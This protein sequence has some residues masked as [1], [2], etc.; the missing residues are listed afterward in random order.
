MLDRAVNGTAQFALI[1]G[2]A[3]VGKSSLLD[4]FAGR[5]G[6][7][8]LV[9]SCL[10][11]GEHGVPFA[12]IVE[13]LRSMES[14]PRHAAF[15][16]AGLGSLE[17]TEPAIATGAPEPTSR[18][19]LFQSVLALLARLARSGST[20][21]VI[22]DIHWA[23]R[24][25]RD[26]LSFL[27]P[28][29]R[30][31]PLLVVMT[32]RTEDVHR[33]HPL[34][35]TLAEFQR[36]PSVEHFDILSFDR[37]L[38]A[39]HI[40]NL[41]G[42]QP[43][44]ALVDAVMQ[45]TEGNPYFIEE[46]AAADSFTG[47][48][49]PASLRELLLVRTDVLS[50][51]ARRT[52]RILA[53][54]DS[55][56]DDRSLA[57]VAQQP[58]DDVREHVRE[59]I[60]R[61][62]L[63]QTATGTRFA[64][65]LL[66]E[67]LKDDLLVGERAEYH[68]ALANLLDAEVDRVASNRAGS[69]ALLAHHRAGAGDMAGALQAWSM[70]AT[71][72]EEIFA[73][74]EA[75]HHLSRIIA[76]WN[77][78]P[79]AE[80]LVDAPY[81]EVV[82]RAAENAFMAGSADVACALAREAIELVDA[83]DHPRR[84]GVL[85]ERLA[86]YVRDTADADQALQLVRRAVDLVPSEPPSTDRA[87]VLAG[88]AGQLMTDGQYGE[89]RRLATEAVEM[90]RACGSV[91][92]ESD[93]LNTLG[94]LAT[95]IDDV[96]LGISLIRT[97]R[98]LAERSG[99]PHQQMRSYWNAVSCL[100]DAGE[101]ERALVAFHEAE[102]QLPRLGLEHLLPDLFANA[103][104]ILLRLGRWDEAQAI[105]DEARERFT[106]ETD[107]PVMSELLAERGDF[108]TARELIG[109]RLARHVFTDR[110][111]QGWPLVH[112]AALEN[113]QG[114]H[115]AARVAVD[116]ALEITAGTESPMATAYALAI[117][118]RCEADVAE[119]AR[120]YDHTAEEERANSRARSFVDHMSTLM[121]RPGPAEGWKREVGALRLQCDAE[122]LR[123]GGIG[124]PTAWATVTAAWDA[125]NMP[126]HG[127]YT[128][129][130]QA[131][132]AIVVATERD[133]VSELL[134]EAHRVSCSLGAAPLQL[135]IEAFARRC[136]LEIGTTQLDLHP[137]LT[138]REHEVLQRLSAG[139]TNRQIAAALFISEKTASVHV[140]NVI[141]KLGVSNRGQAAALAHRSGLVT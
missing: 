21:L 8:L 57:L 120:R 129:F 29:L 23:D 79:S 70:A 44:S 28:N 119:H 128:R 6:M 26:L 104:D 32:Y 52:L 122:L 3:G 68:A 101:W 2:A 1:A 40:A 89:A 5:A 9:G 74:A 127:A 24:S 96:E 117:G 87:R 20:I 22:E 78:A 131:E 48:T 30:S 99:D 17:P 45:R 12:P 95:M 27:I 137:A 49:L 11:L 13:I 121:Q 90:A 132:A 108:D 133:R 109:A 105:V 37:V 107:V 92:A 86:R 18:V 102:A 124:D 88:L 126:Y 7:P 38:A 118:C 66:R 138:K 58:V 47:G 84:S 59:A 34:R 10:P 53:L 69:L 42:A 62:L 60:D 54:A 51:D 65:A 98:E 140:S 77:R 73:F 113:W 136:R 130:R 56:V 80:A 82:A 135:M 31:E 64:H 141:R 116:E 61:R 72:A 103:A 39:A 97:A 35:P 50:A 4:E 75:H 36:N 55:Q 41:T 112:L 71:A 76:N 46:L 106:D 93:A 91:L 19:Q 16:P 139:D 110:E 63:V 115:D 111:Q 125:M 25:T 33:D 85:H 123:A 81:H 14:D 43:A 67:V 134:M 114:H 94:V 83:V 15:F 100:S